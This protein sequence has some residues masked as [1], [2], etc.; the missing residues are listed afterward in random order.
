MFDEKFTRMDSSKLCE[1]TSA[2]HALEF[3]P[4]VDV[5]SK[6]IARLIRGRS[7]EQIRELFGLPDDL[8]EE[9]KLEPL[10]HGFGPLETRIRLLNHLNARKRQ[11]LLQGKNKNASESASASQDPALR[12]KKDDRPI[13]ELLSFIEDTDR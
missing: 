5:G 8:T 10:P 3:T 6:G 2:A 4:L 13:D 11:Q 7:P 12:A 1:L 9:E